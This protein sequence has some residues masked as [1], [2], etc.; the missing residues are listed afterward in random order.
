MKYHFVWDENF[1]GNQMFELSER[2]KNIVIATIIGG[3]NAIFT[4]YR[5]ERLVKAIKLLRNVDTPFVSVESSIEWKSLI[6][7]HSEKGVTQGVVTDANHGFLHFSNISSQGSGVVSWLLTVMG[8]GW[9][10]LCYASEVVELPAKFQL[11]AEASNLNSNINGIIDCCD[12][13]Y[14]CPKDCIRNLYSVDDLRRSINRAEHQLSL[15]HIRNNSKISNINDI[16]PT[17]VALAQIEEEHIS[18]ET[19][20]L[21]RTIADIF[22]HNKTFGADLIEAKNC[23]NICM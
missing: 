6:G 17:S 21:G 15:G 5:T 16:E 22:G 9:I 4:G 1:L 7:H 18:L 8:N 10:R 2:E 14:D 3:H 20:R 11:I 23:Q 12:I 19:A 13:R